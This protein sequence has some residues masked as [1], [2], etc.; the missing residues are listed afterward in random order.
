MLINTKQC[1]SKICH[2]KKLIN[3]FTLVVIIIYSSLSFGQ[4]A[5]IGKL[6]YW[7]DPEVWQVN[8]KEPTAYFIP[9]TSK[10]K[11][12]KDIFKSELI[13]LLNGVWKFNL[14]TKPADRPLD[15]YKNEYN[16]NDWDEI[17][18]PSNW[19]LEGYDVPIYTNV[20][21][22][23]EK[24]PPK[25]QEHYN[26]V[27]SYKRTFS[28]PDNWNNKEVILHFG[29]VSSAMYVWV[30]EEQVGYSEDSKTPAEFN[31]TKYLK[32]GE[33]TLSVQVFR[34][35]DASYLEDQ[36]FWRL[37]G[38]TRDV[39]LIA[40]DKQ[41]IHD[42]TVTSPLINNFK[43]GQLDV[44]VDIVNNAKKAARVKVLWSIENENSRIKSGILEKTL[45]SGK[46]TFQFKS[47]IQEAK[48]WTAETPNLYTLYIELQNKKGETI[49]VIKQDVGFRTIEIK[50][51][52]LHVNGQYIY[53][54]GVNLHEH[55]DINGHVVD[56]KTMLKDIKIMKAHNINAV[57]T[58]HYPQPERWYELCNKY[59]LYLI[60]EAN[61]ESH[62]MGAELQAPFDKNIHVAYLENWNGAHLARIKNMV[63]RD[64][65]QP[66]IIIWSMGNECGNG[67]VFYEAYEWIK[68]KDKTRLV[69]FEQAGEN[70]NTDIVC[71][72]YASIENLEKY[73]L[74]NPNRPLIQCEYAHAMGNSVGNLQDYWDVIEKYKSLQGGF[75]WDWVDQ[76]ILTQ[77][78]S[79]EAYWAYGGDFGSDDVP[80]DGNF[81]LNGL[82]NPDRQVKP[83]L[84]EVKKV[85]QYV[86]FEAI[87]LESGTIEITN[88]YSFINLK[89]FT[90]HWEVLE[91]GISVKSGDKPVPSINPYERKKV[92]LNVSID[93]KDDS[94]YF[95]NIYI[96]TKE[97]ENLIPKEHI[98][99]YK[100]FS[101][102]QPKVKPS[103]KSK[104]SIPNIVETKKSFEISSPGFV[105]TISKESGQL[106]QYKLG[107]NELLLK[108]LVPNF[109][110][111]PIDNDYGNDF[112]II[113]KMWRKAGERTQEVKVVP[114]KNDSCV[115]VSSTMMLCDQEGKVIADYKTVYSIFGNG[116]VIVNNLFIKID[117]TPEIMRMGMSMQMPREYENMA[118]YGRGPHESYWDR[119][120]SALV[121]HYSGLVKD[122]SWAYL[123]PQEN[124]NKTDVRWMSLTNNQ[125]KG[126]M[127]KGLPL[128]DVT[129]R[130][131]IM[132]DL[133]S[134]GRTDGRQREGVKPVNRHTFDVKPRNLTTVNIDYK[135]MGVGGDTSWGAWTHKKYRL[136]KNQYSYSFIIEPISK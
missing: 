21:Y 104:E 31:I 116:A 20:Q 136:C 81:C 117:S 54:K 130:H 82:V 119:K 50:D 52:T 103:T 108:G 107:E 62:G 74:K 112:P 93:K 87:D 60:D 125:G 94:E 77:S 51:N 17:K 42:F 3:H 19:E 66:S 121:G 23:H 118:W 100:Q 15:F 83:H 78:Q 68:S 111:A 33:N 95:L 126:L 32:D 63:E 43:D 57:R 8:K 38:I 105:V 84:H 101:I 9:F 37:S 5:P 85:Y 76:G 22:P 4:I 69:Q 109:W 79:G 64:K 71:P 61:I 25:I 102:A 96:K 14:V 122:Q 26:P 36:D 135:Q 131:Q 39:Y 133:E 10:N 35:S 73:A 56:E 88:K 123:R 86:G 75:I 97:E 59:G 45:T 27:G 47:L 41:H 18:V 124:G 7:Q 67:P 58:A 55:H 13:S 110:R 98:V 115:Q 106:T 11:I 90:L 128:I 70:K 65:N 40:R 48:P 91:N 132:E 49:E 2:L 134:K 92:N 12:Q 28:I 72:M 99:A 127:F 1:Y 120:T 30:N 44:S 34:W 114:E 46:S 129:A 6:P 89:S 53:L 24:T 113:S 29:A 80:S 16:T